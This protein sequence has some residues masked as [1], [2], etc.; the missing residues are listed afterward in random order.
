MGDLGRKT[1]GVSLFKVAHLQQTWAQRRV[2]ATCIQ[3][4]PGFSL[5]REVG[6]NLRGGVRKRINSFHLHLNRSIPGIL[7]GRHSLVEFGSPQCSCLRRG[8]AVLL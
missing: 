7:T 5:Y 6:S 3:D 4:L 8:E 1:L 2:H